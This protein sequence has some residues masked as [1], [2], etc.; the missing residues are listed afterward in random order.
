MFDLHGVAHP[1]S[2]TRPGRC[3]RDR[4]RHSRPCD[5]PSNPAVPH[6]APASRFSPEEGAR[7]GDRIARLL[8]RGCDRLELV[9]GSARRDLNA[10]RA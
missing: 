2:G 10:R 1:S 4:A 5:D 7:A 6:D 3:R 9:S 8:D